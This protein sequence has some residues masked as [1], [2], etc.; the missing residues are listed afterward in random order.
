MTGLLVGEMG[1]VN[2]L[3][4]ES[5]ARRVTHSNRPPVSPMDFRLKHPLAAA[6]EQPTS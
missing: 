3:K 1:Q 2:T 5:L 4:R 6:F